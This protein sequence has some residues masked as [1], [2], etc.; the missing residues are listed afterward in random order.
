MMNVLTNSETNSETNSRVSGD[1][2][3][4]DEVSRGDEFPRDSVARLLLIQNL[5][6]K[7]GE[8][9]QS[10]YLLDKAL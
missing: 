2:V 7:W 4:H 9:F 3:L 10:T 5:L 1:V 6:V 8:C